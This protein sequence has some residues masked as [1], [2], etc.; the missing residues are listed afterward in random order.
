[1]ALPATIAVRRHVLEV[2]VRGS[3]NDGLL[4]QRHLSGTVHG[5]VARA[6]ETALA[7]VVPEDDRLVVDRLD[8]EVDDVPYDALDDALTQAVRRDVEAFFRRHLPPPDGRTGRSADAPGPTTGANG[9]IVRWG[10]AATV[11]EAFVAFLRDGRLPWAFRPAHDDLERAVSDAWAGDIPAD[12]LGREALVHALDAP[13]VRLRVVKQFSASFVHDMVDRVAPRVAGPL[14]EASGLRAAPEP[15]GP[16]WRSAF[17][18]QV[19]L[20]AL[21]AVAERRTVTAEE[22][23]RRAL[24]ALPEQVRA[25]PE[26]VQHLGRRWPLVSLD[27]PTTLAPGRPRA[28]RAAVRDSAHE[29]GRM[30]AGATGDV[31]SL[32]VDHA[33]LVLLHPFLPRFLAGLGV[34]AGEELLD[35][36]RAVALLHH[37][38]TGDAVVPEQA[39]PLAKVLCGMSLGEP[40]ERDP[41]LTE[42]EVT[43]ATA[44]LEAVVGHWEALRNTSPDT[45]RAE[46]LTRAGTLSAE[47]GDW[48]LRV[49]DRS[50]D[51]LLE[52]L[53]WGISMVQTPWMER[54][55][56]VEW[57]D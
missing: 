44:L 31:T 45:L 4:V 15:H 16:G 39:T 24:A 25:D 53:P 35:A 56:R 8:I 52:E 12:A 11:Q 47:G 27:V 33:G 22:L 3:E 49:E 29:A 26:L 55:L 7:G 36:D 2:D 38:A 50:V 54:M 48:V 42:D 46:F 32:L 28:A 18:R 40:V 10:P 41:D 6:L 43:E 14:A 13:V 51:I 57:R 9:P 1:M 20:A 34:A 23:V 30:P 37:L 5:L 21:T 17:L 19:E